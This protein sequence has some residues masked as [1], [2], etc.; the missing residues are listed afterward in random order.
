MGQGP[1]EQAALRC[2]VG[3]AGLRV[4]LGMLHVPVS[5]FCTPT[6]VLHPIIP[7]AKRCAASP[8][9][10]LDHPWAPLL[11]LNMPG[12]PATAPPPRFRNLGKGQLIESWKNFLSDV[13]VPLLALETDPRDEAAAAQLAAA[14]AQAAYLIKGASLLAPDTLAT[15]M[16][17]GAWEI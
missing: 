1:A 6:A 7:A 9:S 5:G 14:A 15:A 12:T 10:V 16:Q 13:A 3:G 8:S 2:G 11:Q 17:V 4:D